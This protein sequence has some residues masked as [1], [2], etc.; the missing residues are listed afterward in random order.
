MQR[1]SP[2][3]QWTTRRPVRVLL[4]LAVVVAIAFL[5]AWPFVR[6]HLQA[7]AILDLVSGQP[8]PAPIKAVA[9]EEVMTQD[10]TIPGSHGPIHARLYAPKGRSDAPAIIVLHGVHHLGM[11]E[12]RLIAFASAMSRCGLRVLTPELPGIKDYQ[13]SPESIRTIGESAMWLGT[14]NPGG[15]RKPVG[16]M[17][18]SFSGGLSLLAAADPVYQPSISFVVAIGSQDQMV[19]V[20]KY[21]RTGE[22]ARPKGAPELLTPHEYGALVLEYEHPEDFVSAADVPG[23]RAVLRAHLYEDGPGEKAAMAA[24]TTAQQAEVRGMLNTT[25]PEIHAKLEAGEARHEADMAAVSP[26]GHLEKLAV[27]VYLL[28]GAGDNIIPASETE[29]MAAELPPTSLKSVLISPVLSHL[30]LDGAGPT[31]KDRW[32]L[33]HFFALIL[34]N[35]HS[36]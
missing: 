22:G 32:Q 26:H 4:I 16:V 31:A 6:L 9:S 3:K 30:N 24:L 21:Y 23:V 19:R 29:W 35:A 1:T 25:S 34:H 27:P 10:V 8:L 20:A 2:S 12:P 18:L 7:V 13:V 11:E 17:G 5:A 36:E 14:Q 33:V 28:H 15:V